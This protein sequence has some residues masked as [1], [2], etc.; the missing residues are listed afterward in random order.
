M[1]GALLLTKSDVE[2]IFSKIS[3][4]PEQRGVAALKRAFTDLARYYRNSLVPCAVC[5]KGVP[6]GSEPWRSIIHSS[7]N[8]THLECNPGSLES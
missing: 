7:L 3:A 1:K 5:D 8:L 2:E 6:I 4:A